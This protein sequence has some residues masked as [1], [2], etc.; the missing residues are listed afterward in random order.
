MT[1]FPCLPRE[2]W[3]ERGGRVAGIVNS[4]AKRRIAVG[5]I[6]VIVMCLGLTVRSWAATT[7][8]NQTIGLGPVDLRLSYNTGVAFSLGNGAPTW[9]VLAL[10][11]AVTLVL[12]TVAWRTAKAPGTVR[13]VALGLILGGAEA[14]LIDR[15][16]DGAVLDYIY[17][18]WFATFNLPDTAI[19]TGA[20]LLIL[21][22]WRTDRELSRADAT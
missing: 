16:A 18:G 21:A 9:V 19:V 17:T 10:A 11:G 12:C 6:A 5:V 2:P 13:I 3:V 4:A 15:A 7:L 14:N 8:A 1:H 20:A 22:F